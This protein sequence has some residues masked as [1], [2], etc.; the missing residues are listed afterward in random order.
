[1]AHAAAQHANI[2]CSTNLLSQSVMLMRLLLMS[3]QV[4]CVKCITMCHGTAGTDD[5]A[6][7]ASDNTS[8]VQH[9]TP[10]ISNLHF[11]GNSEHTLEGERPA[12]QPC[13]PP[14]CHALQSRGQM[15]GQASHLTA[16]L[17]SPLRALWPAELVVLPAGALHGF[18]H[19][20][21]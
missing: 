15:Q 21:W 9:I 12:A 17:V 16:C 6:C 11:H 1:M 8:A 18:Q 10:N 13:P 20:C 19:L 4:C 7:L 5:I 3:R 14:P 2:L